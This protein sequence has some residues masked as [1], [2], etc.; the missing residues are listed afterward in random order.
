[1]IYRVL[2]F[3]LVFSVSECVP[4]LKAEDSNRDEPAV[5]T[6]TETEMPGLIAEEK[7]TLWGFPPVIQISKGENDMKVVVEPHVLM[8]REKIPDIESVRLETE[9][10]EFLGLKA[11]GPNEEKR[12]AEFL[13][14]PSV[15]ETEKI[16]VTVT[17]KVDGIWTTAVPLEETPGE[18]PMLYT[19][20]AGKEEEG[21]K[22]EASAP[23]EVPQES[24]EPEP[25]EPAKKKKKGWFW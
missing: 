21:A 22:E 13:L 3:L 18:L 19:Q 15:I 17:S 5:E 2:F 6:S 1:M 23:E 4:P 9:K 14:D 11:F 25:P 7:A 16:K 24:A 20:P 10:G 8:E 12:R